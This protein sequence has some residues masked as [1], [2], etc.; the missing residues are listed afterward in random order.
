MATAREGVL[1]LVKRQAKQ[2]PREVLEAARVMAT[3]EVVSLD[4]NAKRL[5]TRASK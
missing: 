5:R 3:A 1:D 2:R 4:L